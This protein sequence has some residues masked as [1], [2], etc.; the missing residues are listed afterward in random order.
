[1]TRTL[2]ALATLLTL[3]APALAGDGGSSRKSARFTGWFVPCAADAATLCPVV[4]SPA[5]APNSVVW[6]APPAGLTFE[7]GTTRTFFYRPLLADQPEG[8]G[9]A[10]ELWGKHKS[11]PVAP[12]T[13]FVFGAEG[14]RARATPYLTVSGD[15][16]GQLVDGTAFACASPAICA[17]LRDRLAAGG[18]IAVTFRFSAPGASPLIV[19][20]KIGPEAVPAVE[21][22]PPPAA[23]APPAAPLVPAPPAPK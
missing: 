20:E 4:H 11:A 22:T 21:V 8:S 10:R 17:A 1:M 6:S 16:G 5:D 2:A 15:A 14:D 9:T 18:P 3:A 13:T 7:W 12:G 23:P 19:A